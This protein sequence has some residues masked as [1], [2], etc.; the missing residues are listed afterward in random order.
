MKLHDASSNLF[1]PH[2]FLK[3]CHSLGAGGAQVD[4]GI[5][6]AKATKQLRDY[7]ETNGLFIEAIV[8]P[9]KDHSDLARF[10]SEIKAARHV[11]AKAARTVIIPGR[12]YEHFKT[13][14]EFKEAEKRAEVM[15]LMAFPVVEKHEVP[16]AIEALAPFAMSVHFKD[17]A[18]KEYDDGFLLGDIPLGQGSFDLLRMRD[19]LRAVKPKLQF[20][21]EVITRD[22]FQVPCLK[23]A[24]WESVTEPTGLD[25]ARTLS[26][27]R[28]H[29]VDSQSINSLPLAAQVEMEDANISQS[30]AYASKELW[31]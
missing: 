26:F 23:A 21:L 13:Y 8:N 4:L 22:A 14:T 2:T 16:L 20:C 24:Y 1:S 30:L 12:R 11:N 6:D 9:P 15:A 19:I 18:L 25:L 27:V 5:L 10:E 7:A 3:H 28:A 29:Q 17:Q 31:L